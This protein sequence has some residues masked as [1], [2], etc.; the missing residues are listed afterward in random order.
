MFWIVLA[1]YYLL[2]LAYSFWLKSLVLVDTITL[3]GLYTA[4]IIAGSMALDLT[5]S[6]WLL[7]FSVFLFYS[8]ALVKRYAEMDSM[9]RQ[10]KLKAAGRGYHIDDL[11]I[12]HSLGTA[13]GNLCV[14][15]LALYIN[16]PAVL[17]LYRY[18][19]AIWF[20]CVLLLYWISR[21]WLKTHRGK[22]HD[23]PVIFAIKD[24][25]SLAVVLAAA[26]TIILAI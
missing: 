12:L 22:M 18:P 21:I 25:I 3:A 13:S 14:L 17:P 9:L 10:N 15:V 7:L 20:L 23:D 1:G 6:F 19:E 2:T 8:L 5:L 16:S 11:P 24:K 26:L 4:R